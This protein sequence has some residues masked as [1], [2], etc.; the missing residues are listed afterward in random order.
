MPSP[1]EF[2]YD[3]PWLYDLRTAHLRDDIRWFLREAART[4]GEVLELACGTGRVAIPLARTGIRVVGVDAD[5]G[6]LA[7]GREHARE[8]G[9]EVRWVC[10]DMMRPLF[11]SRFRLVY[12][13][14]ASLHDLPRWTD[15][16]ACFR[17][18]AESLEPGGRFLLDDH[19]P[20]VSTGG[21]VEHVRL[22]CGP[23]GGPVDAYHTVEVDSAAQTT[24]G[25]ILYHLHD[26]AGTLTIR[27]FPYRGSFAHPTQVESMMRRAGLRPVERRGDYE[28]GAWRE[29]GPR[30]L[31]HAVR[32]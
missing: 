7:R 3:D 6:M 26:A 10:A 12:V 30:T 15:W 11:R 25:E 9:A 14:F 4:D 28:G 20:P 1:E 27:R 24:R 2:G 21:E 5:R 8:R 32:D 16:E 18:A 23:T 19:A 13:A 31:F 17:S 22:P 29:G